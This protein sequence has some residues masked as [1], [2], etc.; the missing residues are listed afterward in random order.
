MNR[1][2]ASIFAL[3]ALVFCA[4]IGG[5]LFLLYPLLRSWGNLEQTA[6]IER[7][8]AI[9]K[10]V[11]PFDVVVMNDDEIRIVTH[12][13]DAAQKGFMGMLYL[14]ILKDGSCILQETVGA[15][16]LVRATQVAEGGISRHI[17]AFTN[18]WWSIMK[19]CGVKHTE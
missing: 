18:G 1:D 3:R 11:D 14:P 16:G 13:L 4:M 5:I 10:K 15:T 6:R 8:M 17:P 9:L 19:G 2:K 7:G 12:K